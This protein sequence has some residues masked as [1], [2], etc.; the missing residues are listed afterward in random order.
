MQTWIFYVNSFAL[1]TRLLQISEIQQAYPLLEGLL[2]LTIVLVMEGVNCES[3]AVCHSAA[4]CC[5]Q[6]RE[7]PEQGL[8]RF[9]SPETAALWLCSS[10]TAPTVSAQGTEQVLSWR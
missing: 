3:C 7:L 2:G 9:L 8:S 5:T 10:A 6:H 1:C 4:W